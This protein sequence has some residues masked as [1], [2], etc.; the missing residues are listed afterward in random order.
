MKVY[1]KRQMVSVFFYEKP[2]EYDDRGYLRANR[3]EKEKLIH[4]MKVTRF[5][6]QNRHYF[7]LLK[8]AQLQANHMDRKIEVGYSFYVEGKKT[9][10]QRRASS[11]A[12][13]KG[14][15]TKIENAMKQ[16]REQREKEL[17]WEPENDTQWQKALVKL[18]QK[19]Q[20]LKE[21]IK[22]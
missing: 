21:L 3:R 22:T 11:I 4:F 19:K 18:D 1:H 7:F 17:F 13:A 10:E 6:Y 12:S 15:I 9:E 20:K 14:Q 5:S 8:L 16:Y 2:W